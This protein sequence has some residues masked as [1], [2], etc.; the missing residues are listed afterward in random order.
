M[1]FNKRPTK[2]LLIGGGSI[3]IAVL[4]HAFFFY[5]WANDRFMVGPNDGLGQMLPFKHFYMI[6][7]KKENSFIPFSLD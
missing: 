6:N 5:E 1:R 4:T 7:T 2:W 3:I